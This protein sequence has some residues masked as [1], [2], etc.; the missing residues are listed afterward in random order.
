MADPAGSRPDGRLG[1][2]HARM[3]SGAVPA[4][5]DQLGSPREKLVYLSLASVPGARADELR[6]VL[7]MRLLELYPVLDVLVE[8]GLVERDGTYYRC[9]S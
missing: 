8:R 3:E 2:V 7:S 9:L 5:P 6:E 4:M 1:G